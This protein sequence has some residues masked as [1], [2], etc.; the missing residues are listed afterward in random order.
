MATKVVSSFYWM[1]WSFPIK[2]PY[3]R[4][5]I[6]THPLNS[7]FTVSRFSCVFQV[8][9]IY[10][11]K[12]SSGATRP[13]TL[14]CH[15]HWAHW[16]WRWRG[17][18][19][20][21]GVSPILPGVDC[22]ELS[23]VAADLWCLKS[24]RRLSRMRAPLTALFSPCGDLEK[25][26]KLP[27]GPRPVLVKEFQ[28]CGWNEYLTWLA[29]CFREHRSSR[30]IVFTFHELPVL[31]APLICSHCLSVGHLSASQLISLWVHPNNA[32]HK[33]LVFPS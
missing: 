24:C 4:I 5:E 28:T 32:L 7:W 27:R 11:E 12:T 19:Q 14:K 30:G 10:G 21:S 25:L 1:C 17:L 29:L 20:S 8:G 6:L 33:P 9:L 22:D 26:S 18:L 2:A 15:S 23:V 31:S 3:S 16:W 13:I